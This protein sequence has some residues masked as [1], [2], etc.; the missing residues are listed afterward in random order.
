MTYEHPG[1]G[2]LDYYPCRY[3]TSK[4]LFRGPRRALDRPYCVALGGTETYG[5][6]IDMPWPALLER[7]A[8][9]PVVNL[10]C[11][12]AGLDCYLNDPVL[13]GIAAG[14]D[15]RV[16][17][18]L[19]AHNLSNRFYAVHPRRNDRFLRPNPP[20]LR[21]YPDLDFT[22]YS[23]TRHLL[24]SLARHAP[25]RFEPVVSELRQ[26]WMD[27]MAALLDRIGGPTVLLW[28]GRR[29]PARRPRRSPPFADPVLVDADMLRRVSSHAARLVEVLL[30][31]GTGPAEGMQFAPLEAAA[32]AGLPGPAVHARIARALHP[33]VARP[34]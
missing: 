1:A 12:N 27:R 4:L 22:E 2:A 24:S 3:G 10:G 11:V 23:F 29:P 6:F 30:D 33:V 5:K 20:L 31:P 8:G 17:Q 7:D 18:V 13:T 32:A 26:V 9:R 19:G 16:V 25:D 21:L 34:H 15:L 14:A 28:L